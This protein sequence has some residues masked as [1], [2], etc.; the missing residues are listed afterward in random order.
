[1]ERSVIDYNNYQCAILDLDGTLLRSTNVWKE[2]DCKFMGERNIPITPEFTEK[3]K[4][5]NFEKG[6]EYVVQEYGLSETKEEVMKLWFDMAM[7]AYANDI[8][9][10]EYARE[11][12]YFLKK[13]GYKLAVATSS[14]E[15]LFKP[16]LKR[17]GIYDLFDTFT[18]AK[19]VERGKN[20]PDIY[21]KAAQKTGVAPDK[22]IVFEDVL[23]AVRAAKSGGFFVVAVADELSVSDEDEIRRCADVFISSYK[24][25][26]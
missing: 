22:C 2:I 19:E 23:G 6:A 25:L 11:Y 1:M 8:L 3:I 16:C 12:L 20:Y 26:I 10:K 21:L 18:Q 14:D 17:N 5:L 15:I 13:K 24:E 7:D 9:L 4:L